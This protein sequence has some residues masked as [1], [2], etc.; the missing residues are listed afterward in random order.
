THSLTS[1]SVGAES[2]QAKAHASSLYLLFYY[3]GSS[4]V[5]SA[6]GWFWLH[7]GWSAIVGL[8]VF[9]S[10]IGIFL[11]VYTSHAKAH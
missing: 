3:M 11:A 4:I 10:L 9:L 2:K 1:S 7:G 6:G 8:T 5:G